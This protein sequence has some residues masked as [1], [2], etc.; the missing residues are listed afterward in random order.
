MNKKEHEEKQKETK[1]N[2]IEKLKTKN[3]NEINKQNVYDCYNFCHFNHALCNS[4]VFYMDGCYN[5]IKL[6]AKF[7]K[8]NNNSRQYLSI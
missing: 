5:V 1:Q 4:N 3:Q 7:S 6:S 8:N 2:Q